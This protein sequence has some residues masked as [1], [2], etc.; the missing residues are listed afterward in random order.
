MSVLA[1]VSDRVLL[2]ELIR[3]NGQGRAPTTRTI[4]GDFRETFVGVGADHT[5]S[6]TYPAEVLEDLAIGG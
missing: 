4:S 1:E 2:A 6:I 3:R 5:V